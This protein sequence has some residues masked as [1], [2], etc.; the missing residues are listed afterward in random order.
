MLLFFHFTVIHAGEPLFV[1]HGAGAMG[2]AFSVTATP[3]H[4]NCFHNQAL[5]T[6]VPSS[7]FSIGLENR[8]MMPALSSKAVSGV[9]A[10]NPLPWGS[11]F[12]ITVTLTTSGFSRAWQ[13]CQ[14]SVTASPL[15]SR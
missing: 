8:F 7:G 9:L 5:L 2:V 15:V 11:W 12:L 13:R 3:G 6:A 4:W 1:P 14:G 10:S